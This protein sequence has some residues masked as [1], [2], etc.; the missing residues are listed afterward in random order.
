MSREVKVGAL[1]LL[2]LATLAAGVFLVG[3]RQNLFRRTG[4]YYVR[5]SSA[6]GLDTGNPV[7]LSG[8]TVGRI[9]DVRLPTEVADPLLTVWISIDRRYVQRVREDSLARIKTL[10]LLGD[11]YVEI[12]SGSPESPAVLT[13]GEIHA[14]PATDVDQL[15]ASGED[16]VDNV[17]AISQLLRK[18][19]TQMDRGEGLLGALVADT[20]SGEE[21]KKSIRSTLDSVASISA[22]IDHGQGSL[23]RLINDDSL[24]GELEGSAKR[25]GSLLA[26]MET[27]EGLLPALLDDRQTLEKAQRAVDNL[28]QAS[29]ALVGFAHGLQD[30]KGLLPQLM[31]DSEY[32]EAVAKDIQ[33][34]VHNLN[35]VSERLEQG[36][37]TVGQLINDP[38][39]Y[40]AVNDVLLGINESR[41]LRW[42]IGNR[43]KKGSQKRTKETS[44]EMASEMAS[45]APA[46]GTNH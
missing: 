16:A 6:S 10:G 22:K 26:K 31:S 38:Q 21:V 25:L 13:G 12:T 32:G 2:A 3:E 8:V 42:L 41:F 1:V 35:L 27:G 37:G 36:G 29:D 30:G 19:L 9:Q 33:E 43:R 15:I 18:I 17:V 46:E 39:V 23:G 24:A 28:S 45:E 40:E 11:K 14:A 34:L 7:K 5:F 20:E 44:A 4:D